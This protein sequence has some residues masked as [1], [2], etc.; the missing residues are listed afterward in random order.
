MS[1]SF[2]LPHDVACTIFYDLC[3]V[4]AMLTMY[5]VYVRLQSSVTLNTYKFFVT[6]QTCELPAV[7]LN[8]EKIN[9]LP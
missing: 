1:V 9:K 8:V 5:V 7:N 4:V 6:F 2:C 3:A